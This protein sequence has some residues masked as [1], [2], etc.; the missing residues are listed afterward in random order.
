MLVREQLTGVGCLF[1][2]CR[3]RGSRSVW[4][5]WWPPPQPQRTLLV[6]WAGP[7]WAGPCS[8]PYTD[9]LR[10]LPSRL[11]EGAFQVVVPVL[12]LGWYI[13][14]LEAFRSMT[15]SYFCRNKHRQFIIL[16]LW[17]PEVRHVELP[18]STMCL[19]RCQ[20]V[21]CAASA[22]ALPCGDVTLMSSPVRTLTH[23]CVFYPP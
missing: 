3:L 15:C 20:S 2:L 22:V 12:S 18:S 10:L 21:L 13:K 17:R 6:C 7:E 14:I 8:R 11:P 4:Q 16:Q 5:A 23:P 9:G 1:S 19:W